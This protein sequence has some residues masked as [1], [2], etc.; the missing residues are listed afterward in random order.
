MSIEF[1]VPQPK[2]AEVYL[3]ACGMIERRHSNLARQDTLG[4][5]PIQ[6]SKACLTKASLMLLIVV[7]FA[8]KVTWTDGKVEV[9]NTE[10]SYPNPNKMTPLVKVILALC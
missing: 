8:V 10:V 3:S 7:Y 1:H 5:A 4:L 2:A 9:D 6:H